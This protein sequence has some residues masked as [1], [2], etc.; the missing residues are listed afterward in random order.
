V[1]QVQRSALAPYSGDEMFQLV[2]DINQYQDFL[3]WCG[4]STILQTEGDV[5][6]GQVDIDFK[7][8]KQ[9]FSTRNTN[10]QG[11]KIDMTLVDGPFSELSGCWIFRD[12]DKQASQVKLDLKF[13]FAGI[14]VEKLLGPV[15]NT[16]AGSMVDSFVKRAEQVYGPRKLTFN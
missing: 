12:I 10:Y 3:P 6:I 8:L 4:G 2:A 9:R 1:N 13:A 5:V 11:Q 14:V 15:F 7:G 16:I